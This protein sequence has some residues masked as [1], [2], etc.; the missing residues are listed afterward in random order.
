M[1]CNRF[2]MDTNIPK[3]NP[4]ARPADADNWPP[5]E[6]K[7]LE[8]SFEQPPAESTEQPAN[9]PAAATSKPA[10]DL[11]VQG[12]STAQRTELEREIENVLAEDLETIFWN[13]PEP[14]REVFKA[15][16]EETASSIR[17][18]LS[19]TTIRIQEIFRLITEW[20]KSLP[21]VNSIFVEQEAK[22]K[23]DRILK[24]RQ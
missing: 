10:P 6:V 16:G 19:E 18:L 2:I 4:E 3:Q 20:L 21:G 15:K 1:W 14:E 5:R 9:A 22:N 13:L 11:H 24:L 12:A 8:P 7:D 17:T 23:T